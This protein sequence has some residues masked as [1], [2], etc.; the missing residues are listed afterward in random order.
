MAEQS[1][2]W[3]PEDHEIK[4]ELNKNETLEKEITLLEKIKDSVFTQ[5][6]GLLSI[7]ILFICLL[8]LKSF[9]SGE[10]ESPSHQI[11]IMTSTLPLSKG[12]TLEAALLRPVLFNEYSLSKT[13]KMEALTFEAAEKIMGKVRAKKDIPPHKP[14]FWNDLEL[15]PEIKKTASP[16]KPN[17]FFPED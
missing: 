13:Q 5:K 6:K 1:F 17:V 16:S 14:I 9:S 12:S 3:L 8:L 11:E 7:L 4:K 10:K 15:I 2:S